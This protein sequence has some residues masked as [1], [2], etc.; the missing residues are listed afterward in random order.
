MDGTVFHTF[1]VELMAEIVYGGDIQSISIDSLLSMCS[2][3]E[4]NTPT[5]KVAHRAF[6]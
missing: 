2:S 6:F 3:S 4:S 1:T 5:R